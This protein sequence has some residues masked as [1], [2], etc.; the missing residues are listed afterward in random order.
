MST[1]KAYRRY[2]S[3]LLVFLVTGLVLLVVDIIQ[4][5][6]GTLTT[7]P[8]ENAQAASVPDAPPVAGHGD[9]W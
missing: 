8:N 3:V 5:Q 7:A 9:D 4:R 6:R 1:K 2:L